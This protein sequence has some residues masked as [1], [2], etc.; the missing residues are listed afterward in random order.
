MSAT[1]RALWAGD[2][3][4]SGPREVRVGLRG[5]RGEAPPKKFA[6]A[7]KATQLVGGVVELLRWVSG[8][9]T[10]TSLKASATAGATN[11]TVYRNG[12][13]VPGWEDQPAGTTTAAYT[14]TGGS[15]TI[16][17]G[18]TL[19]VSFEASATQ[20]NLGFSE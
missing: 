18:D 20:L 16:V 10:L 5:P 8:S 3:G 11:F 2:V 7:P 4:T 9:I 13:P 12:D 19:W 17:D 6:V 15:V 14:P 1:F